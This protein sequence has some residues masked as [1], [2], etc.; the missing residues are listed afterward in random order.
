MDVHQR[1][2]VALFSVS[3]AACSSKSSN[4]VFPES[5]VQVVACAEQIVS[6]QFIVE[7]ENG[8]I[9]LESDANAEDFKTNFV[10]ARLTEIKHVEFNKKIKVRPFAHSASDRM[11]IQAGNMVTWGQNMIE[12]D[13]AWAQNIKGQGVKVGVV[14]TAV[15]TSHSQLKKRIHQNLAEVDGQIGVDDDGNGL[16]DDV[17][18]W[19]FLTDSPQA[20]N[21]VV[22]SH[23]THVSG[24]VAADHDEGPIEG[25]APQAE[26][27]PASFLNEA[28]EG[29]LFGALRALNYAAAQGAKVINASW[30]GPRCSQSLRD[31]LLKLS[32][33]DILISVAAGND[34]LDL[35]TSPD[36]PAAFESPTQLTVAALKPS[37]YLAGFSNTSYRYVQI[38]AP[39]ETIYSTVPGDQF[40]EMSGTS[41][42]AP[43]V[44]GAAALLRSF[45]PQATAVQV[46]KALLDSVIKN[47][48]RVASQG[49]L[50]IRRALEQLAKDVP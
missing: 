31:T 35:D 50:N 23:G 5:T 16:I 42:A 24:I 49:R 30:G 10:E 1:L 9:T 46:R 19:D 21:P 2:G 32:D 18:G 47:N 40:T 27:I 34:G 4:S 7:W 11:V 37:G 8:T 36:Y 33:Q 25:I 38:A 3:L 28:G 41:M 20:A 15:D 13:V 44:A 45:R 17:A 14:D 26:I 12:A 48:Y 43:F 6:N 39:G 22:D 29:D